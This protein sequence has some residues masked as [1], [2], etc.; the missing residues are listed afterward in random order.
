HVMRLNDE[1]K[2]KFPTVLA[3]M[4]AQWPSRRTSVK[5]LMGERDKEG[6]EMMALSSIS[7]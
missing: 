7:I 6:R 5:W 2:A 1:A 3:L 4:L